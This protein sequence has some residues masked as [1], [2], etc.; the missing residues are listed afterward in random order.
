MRRVQKYKRRSSCSPTTSS[1]ACPDSPATTLFQDRAGRASGSKGAILIFGNYI[2][3]EWQRQGAT[4]E[5]RNPANTDEV[6]G[7]VRQGH[8]AGRGGC[9]RCGRRGPARLVRDERPGA[10]QHSVQGR[11]HPGPQVRTGGRRHDPRGG[12]DAARSQGRG[13]ALHQHLPLLRRRRLAHARHAG[14]LRA[15]PRPHVRHAQTRSAWWG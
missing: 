10:R 13:A 9:R 12:Q 6:V 14:A 8:G 5:N 15:R 3:G 1:R 11:R 4:F 7:D 2:N